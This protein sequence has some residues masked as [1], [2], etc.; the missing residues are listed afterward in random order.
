MSLLILSLF[1]T[2]NITVFAENLIVQ[3][4]IST[5]EVVTVPKKIE[6]EISHCIEQV[7]GEELAGEIYANV[8]KIAQKSIEARPDYLKKTRFNKK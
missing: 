1:L 5:E 2:S 4:K 7:Y 6:S 8:M 3:N